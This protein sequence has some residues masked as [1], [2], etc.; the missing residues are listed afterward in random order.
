MDAHPARA[1]G[2]RKRRCPGP[3]E[4]S[5]AQWWPLTLDKGVWDVPEGARPM[6]CVA[7]T[8]AGHQE[9][10]RPTGGV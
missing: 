8:W 7:D 1:A 3:H 9:V 6:A 2:A 10:A 5:V 4:W